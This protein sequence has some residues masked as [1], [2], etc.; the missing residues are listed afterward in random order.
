MWMR[1]GRDEWQKREEQ[2]ARLH[3]SRL[4]DDDSGERR[5]ERETHTHT[6]IYMI[7]ANQCS[8][9]VFISPSSSL[10]GAVDC[11]DGYE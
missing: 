9:L 8:A 3:S 2:T 4:N 6:H 10:C 5:G 7:H 11:T 1:R